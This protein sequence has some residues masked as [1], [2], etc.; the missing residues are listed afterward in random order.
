[1]DFIIPGVAI[2]KTV[3]KS[4]SLKANAGTLENVQGRNS[5]ARG[6]KHEGA[7]GGPS[8]EG[9][10]I[11]ATL[12][13]FAPVDT[14]EQRQAA[15][16]K[17]PVTATA[18]GG[19]RFEGTSQAEAQG[20][21]S[22]ARDSAAAAGVQCGQS[23]SCSPGPRGAPP[24]DVPRR[25]PLPWAGLGSLRRAR[26]R[27][28]DLCTLRA[29]RASAAGLRQPPDVPVSEHLKQLASAWG[30]SKGRQLCW[31]FSPAIDQSPRSASC[32]LGKPAHNS[33]LTWLHSFLPGICLREHRTYNL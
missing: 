7:D 5:A 10:R 27:R 25:R 24:A 22:R 18:R 8:A 29:P 17:P 28:P 11:P 13:R 1:M 31:F 33:Q 12:T 6:G 23:P 30:W 15:R 16:M 20:R 3:V 4:P 26:R 32:P 2:R 19:R 9:K 21:D 14:P